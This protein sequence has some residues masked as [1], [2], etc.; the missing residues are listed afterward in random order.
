MIDHKVKAK[1]VEDHRISQ[2]AFAFMAITL[3]PYSGFSLII[4]QL[5][6]DIMRNRMAYR[7]TK[8]DHWP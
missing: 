6:A 8:S 2:H 7:T 1:K 4:D 3:W 5:I